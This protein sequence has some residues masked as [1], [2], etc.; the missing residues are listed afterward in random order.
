MLLFL[1]IYVLY[2]ILCCK[3]CRSDDLRVVPADGKEDEESEEQKQKRMAKI[4][5]YKKKQ[6]CYFAFLSLTIVFMLVLMVSAIVDGS[7]ALTEGTAKF[8]NAG[9]GMMTVAVDSSTGFIKL[10][11]HIASDVVGTTVGSVRDLVVYVADID[12]LVTSMV[13]I[14]TT[15]YGIIPVG[16]ILSQMNATANHIDNATLIMGV[17]NQTVV[18]AIIF[19]RHFENNAQDL[20]QGL[21]H[22][23]H[24]YEKLGYEFDDIDTYI[25]NIQSDVDDLTSSSGSSGVL[26]E[27]IDDLS[28]Y[29]RVADGGYMP[30]ASTFL[31]VTDASTSPSLPFV[32]SDALTNDAASMSILIARLSSISSSL[33]QLPNLNNTVDNLYTINSTLTSIRAS[34]SAAIDRISDIGDTINYIINATLDISD[35][36]SDTQDAIDGLTL[37]PLIQAMSILTNV[38]LPLI[39]DDILELEEMIY[40]ELQ[41]VDVVDSLYIVTVILD[42]VNASIVELPSQ[43][44]SI[45]ETFDQVNDTITTSVSQLNELYSQIVDATT[46][47]YDII[48]ALAST[49]DSVRTANND[50]TDALSSTN[51]LNGLSNLTDSNSLLVAIDLSSLTSTLNALVNTSSVCVVNPTVIVALESLQTLVE[52]SITLLDKSVIDYSRVVKGYCYNDNSILCASDTGC[53]SVGGNCVNYGQFRCYTDQ[54]TICS[55]DSDCASSGDYCLTDHTRATTLLGYMTLLKDS[56][57]VD[58]TIGVM[59]DS[60]TTTMTTLTSIDF[61]DMSTILDSS[62]V[63]YPLDTSLESSLNSSIS[64]VSSM[65]FNDFQSSMSDGT[66]AIDSVDLEA[67]VDN[68]VCCINCVT[69]CCLLKVHLVL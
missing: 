36:M 28:D 26:P 32:I 35:T 60:L 48:D 10:I 25:D 24:L 58:S 63:T 18:D 7:Q 20:V 69:V 44:Q 45:G 9:D 61:D 46:Q 55:D 4:K 38:Q 67:Y 51:L 30:D 47:L 42:N 53:N 19:T 17:C 66:T 21:T 65:N 56:S 3:L 5:L 15:L 31:L 13:Q 37:T 40:K 39:V 57:I 41:I 43:V 54:A 62:R 11:Q 2:V 59:L 49:T 23:E 14:N 12:G 1:A 16:T 64:S 68:L 22:M 34:S 27:T 52:N 8:S 50:L 29:Q 6:M 33:S